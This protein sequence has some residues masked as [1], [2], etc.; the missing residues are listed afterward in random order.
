MALRPERG[1]PSSV[2]ATMSMAVSQKAP[3]KKHRD[4][5]AL[6]RTITSAECGSQ[7]GSRLA[8]PATCPH[9]PFGVAGQHLWLHLDQEWSIKA[10][11][12]LTQRVGKDALAGLVKQHVLA[13][14]DERVQLTAAIQ[15]TIMARVFVERDAAGQALGDGWEDRPLSGLNNDERVMT[16][17]RRHG[18]VTVVE[19]QRVVDGQSFWPVTCSSRSGRRS[20]CWRP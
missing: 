1:R 19:V 4:C 9:F 3:G 11:D 7:R 6:G 12:L 10:L 14:A 8:C 15:Q 5:P 18:R 20:W 17:H 16:R 13:V 2:A